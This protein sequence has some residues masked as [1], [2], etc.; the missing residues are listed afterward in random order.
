MAFWTLP[1]RMQ[2]VHTYFRVGLLSSST[3]ILFTLGR[4]TF[5]VFLLEWLTLL[6]TCI[7]LPQTSH[8]A[9]VFSF[10]KN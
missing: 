10:K 6:P 4:H 2:R 8:L 5:L 3:L 1:E 9:M 7:A